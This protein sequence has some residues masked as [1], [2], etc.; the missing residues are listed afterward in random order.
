V[1][2]AGIVPEALR[3]RVALLGSF[4][5]EPFVPF[6][7]IEG[8]RAGLWLEPYVAPYAQ[9]MLELLNRDSGL[10]RHAPQ[11][12]FV[13]L[14]DDVL[15]DMRWA[16]GEP[17]DASTL[18]AELVHPVCDALSAFRSAG[19]GIVVMND[20]VAMRQDV[21]GTFAFRSN[22]SATQLLA[23]A[24]DLLQS[25]LGRHEGS[26]LFPLSD[27]VSQL[28]RAHAF[29]YRTH[30]MGH[31]SWS[32]A[33]M[34][35]V[36]RRYAG[37]A[38]AAVGQTTKCIVLDLDNTLWGGVLGELGA[39]GIAIGPQRP[40]REF[41]DF[42]RQLLELNQLGILLAVC[43]K[44]NEG[45]A[46]HVLR[47]HPDCLVRE[48][49]VAA[50]RINW[51]DKATNLAELASELNIGLAHMLFIDDSPHERAWVR[52]QLPEVVVPDPPADPSWYAAWLPTLPSLT[53][54]RHTAEDA[55]RTQQYHEE[56]ERK[57]LSLEVHSQ[58][59][60]L[61]A[62]QLRVQIEP[63][64]S[65]SIERVAQLLAKTNQFNLTTRRHDATTLRRHIASGSWRVYTMRVTDRFGDFGLTGVAIAVAGPERWHLDSFLMSCR[66][67]GKSVESALLAA[68]A[69]DAR[70]AG[71]HELT[72][73]FIDSG[74]N[75]PASELLPA[76]GFTR[77]DD[78]LFVRTLD[79]GGPA[80]PD[81]ITDGTRTTHN[82]SG[83]TAVPR[84]VPA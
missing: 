74:R 66:V 53:V 35:E 68:I 42:Q 50:H 75:A 57:R 77:R 69:R 83:I 78:G 19:S 25:E 47:E 28:G 22:R 23:H 70:R 44:N 16:S 12:T 80:W 45:E 31:V 71:A 63:V 36:A 59:D 72:A 18:A 1:L 9:Y 33:L 58:E 11:V 29:N 67:I 37:I 65:T 46:L 43:S 2:G 39:E 73:E 8:A 52:Q 7:R 49:H 38:A 21:T 34:A 20:L 48:Q 24:N 5:V 3:V 62:L 51:R 27:V 10:Y 6:L 13:L 55:R 76:H 14:D 41:L 81:W 56:R 26:Y 84:G 15:S 30:Y 79:D 17:P 61:R 32:D 40:G 60:F 82:D 64:T 54:L 4:T